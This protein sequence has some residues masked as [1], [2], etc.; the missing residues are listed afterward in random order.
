MPCSNCCTTRNPDAAQAAP[1]PGYAQEDLDDDHG[2]PPLP[3]RGDQPSGPGPGSVQ[4]IRTVPQRRH[5]SNNAA[6]PLTSGLRRRAQRWMA[7]VAEQPGP[8]AV[9][10]PG[11]RVADHGLLLRDLFQAAPPRAVGQAGAMPS[12]RGSAGRSVGS[13]P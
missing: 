4:P 5:S 1:S 10:A 6:A 11:E 3:G 7:D 9:R 13:N 8:G 12:G 2:V